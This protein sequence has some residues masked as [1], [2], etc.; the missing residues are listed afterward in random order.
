MS[1][2]HLA[3]GLLA[4]FALFGLIAAA[5]PARAQSAHMRGTLTA[6]SD[7]DI[8]L[9]SRG[10]KSSTIAITDKTG[11][12]LVSKG[13]MK[14]VTSGKFV[15][16]TSVTRD[17]KMVAEEVHVFAESLRGLGEGH[18]PWDRDTE[19]N[20][21][22]NANI[23]KVDSMSGGDVL[24]L[25]YPGG[26]QSITVPADV[27]VVTFD[28]TTKTELTKG[29][30]VFVIMGKDTANPSAAFIVIGADGITPPM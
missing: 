13:S 22:T 23:A 10:G 26:E 15:G 25:N 28:K 19:A 16:I 12:F 18:Y 4:A 27:P 6:V 1:M 5:G 2:R 3:R 20:M 29:R 21:M 17:G 9:E 30:H 8:T 7:H 14:D 11:Y 24:K